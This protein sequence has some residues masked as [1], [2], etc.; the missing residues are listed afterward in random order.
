MI[1][2]AVLVQVNGWQSVFQLS[3]NLVIAPIE[4]GDGVERAAADCLSG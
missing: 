1:S 4:V 2:F 3:M